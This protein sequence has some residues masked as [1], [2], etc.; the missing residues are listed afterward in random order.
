MSVIYWLIPIAALFVALAIKIFFWAVKSDQFEDLERQGLN[1]LFDDEQPNTSAQQAEPLTA[2]QTTP[3]K[4][5]R[6]ADD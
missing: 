5:R 6:N 3:T 2:E 1:I 4:H